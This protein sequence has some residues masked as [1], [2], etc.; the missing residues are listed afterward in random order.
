MSL[1]TFEILLVSNLCCTLSV[2]NTN[3]Y[4]EEYNNP[5]LGL[6]FRV[7]LGIGLGFGPCIVD[8]EL[9]QDLGTYLFILM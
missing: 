4:A 7:G 5:P 3:S 2:S 1:C 8:L 9:P 6:R